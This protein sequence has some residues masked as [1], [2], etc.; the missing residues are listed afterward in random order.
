VELAL[1]ADSP[2][3]DQTRAELVVE[4]RD[5][6]HVGETGLHFVAKLEAGDVRAKL[7]IELARQRARPDELHVS[8]NDVPELRQL[9]QLALAQNATDACDLRIGDRGA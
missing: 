4:H 6:A 7:P 1:E 5:L 9:V 3:F 2:V 8:T